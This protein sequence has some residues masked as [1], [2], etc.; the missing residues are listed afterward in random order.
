MDALGALM[1]IGVGNRLMNDAAKKKLEQD[2][3]MAEIDRTKRAYPTIPEQSQQL[4]QLNPSALEQLLG[5]ISKETSAETRLKNAQA[6]YY[7]NGGAASNDPL[8]ALKAQKII[9]DL[10]NTKTD[11]DFKGR[12]L[13]EAHDKNVTDEA[14]KYSDK[15][16]PYVDTL[17]RLDSIVKQYIDPN[18]N[19]DNY[20]E[21]TNTFKVKDNQSGLDISKKINLP[22]YDIAGKQLGGLGT[23]FNP[24]GEQFISDLEKMSAPEI[25]KLFGSS[26]TASELQAINEMRAKGLFKDESSLMMALGHLNKTMQEEFGQQEAPFLTSDIGREALSNLEKEGKITYRNKYY[27]GK[28]NIGLDLNNLDIKSLAN[29]PDAILQLQSIA[30]GKK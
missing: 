20:D 27:K 30:N 23:L 4:S 10:A 16:K 28:N 11:N 6:G 9:S 22:T 29:N 14:I 15:T 21:K 5:F 2:K 1:G 18:F 12:Q 8:L 26:R 3:L 17:S 13:K 19:F 25:H 24:K 7:E